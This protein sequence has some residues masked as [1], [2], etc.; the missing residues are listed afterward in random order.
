MNDKG[1]S[2]LHKSNAPHK[3]SIRVTGTQ[4]NPSCV[5]AFEGLK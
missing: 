4:A 1:I 2:R 3:L 5:Q